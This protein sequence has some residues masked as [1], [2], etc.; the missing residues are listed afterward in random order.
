MYLKRGYTNQLFATWFIEMQSD[1]ASN[2]VPRLR[3]NGALDGSACQL[4]CLV[5]PATDTPYYVRETICK[6]VSDQSITATYLRCCG[7]FELNPCTEN[8]H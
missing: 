4:L 2:M 8:T 7:D 1:L 3:G 6:W 5:S